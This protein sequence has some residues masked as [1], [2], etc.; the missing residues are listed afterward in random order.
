MQYQSQNQALALSHSMVFSCWYWGGCLTQHPIALWHMY[1]T[2]KRI[3]TFFNIIY[4]CSNSLC[5]FRTGLENKHLMAC[6]MWPIWH[7]SQ[8]Q[9]ALGIHATLETGWIHSIVSYLTTAIVCASSKKMSS[10]PELIKH[11][12]YWCSPSWMFNP[13]SNCPGHI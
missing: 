12:C 11:M 5:F 7:S 6:L 2:K 4:N 3:D 10:S 13:A 8:H 1:T 9:I